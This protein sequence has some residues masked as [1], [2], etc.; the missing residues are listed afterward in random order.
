MFFNLFN[1]QQ[2]K[3]NFI[4]ENLEKN[5]LLNQS[6]TIDSITLI[7]HSEINDQ[8][9]YP[10]GLFDYLEWHLLT[11]LSM[12]YDIL[13]LQN[14]P[15]SQELLQP[16]LHKYLLVGTALYYCYLDYN[17]QIVPH[18][19]AN[20]GICQPSITLYSANFGNRLAFASFHEYATFTRNISLILLSQCLRYISNNI[21][22]I[23]GDLHCENFSQ[24]LAAQDVQQLQDIL[25]NR[26]YLKRKDILRLKDILL[27]NQCHNLLKWPALVVTDNRIDCQAQ[28]KITINDTSK[29]YLQN[30]RIAKDGM[31]IV[32]TNKAANRKLLLLLLWTLAII[33]DAIILAQCARK[34]L[35]INHDSQMIINYLG[36]ISSLL[37]II[38]SIATIIIAKRDNTPMSKQEHQQLMKICTAITDAYNQAPPSNNSIYLYN[39][40]PSTSQAMQPRKNWQYSAFISL[41]NRR[42][43]SMTASQNL[44]L[45]LLANQTITGPAINHT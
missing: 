34:S 41:F 30:L 25:T 10:I 29:N 33:S 3:K 40:V 21:T 4:I 35:P 16:Y 28:A 1:K 31:I 22:I 13:L 18:C 19:I 2:R 15:T 26:N 44:E 37:A 23:N 24:T 5:L 43:N 20:T 9:D 42:T 6:S 39:S 45:S 32:K 17:N 7:E 36:G 8:P 38:Y 14:L 11:Q 27:A 12:Q